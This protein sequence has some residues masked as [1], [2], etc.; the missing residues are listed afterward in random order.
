M[1]AIHEKLVIK[2]EST[3]VF[4]Q[5]MDAALALSVQSH[6]LTQV[7]TFKTVTS[8]CDLSNK[9]SLMQTPY[10]LQLET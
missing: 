4:P 6:L 2:I 10:K 3:W 1:V 8:Y 9:Y 5:Q 7:D